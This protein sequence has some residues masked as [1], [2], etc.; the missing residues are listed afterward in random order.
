MGSALSSALSRSDHLTVKVEG[1]RGW[2]PWAIDVDRLEVADADGIWMVMDN[3]HCRWTMSA[4]MDGRVQIRSLGVQDVAIHRLPHAGESS[5]VKTN[6]SFSLVHPMNIMIDAVDVVRLQIDK[7]VA[8]FPLS[9]SVSSGGIKFLRDGAVLGDLMVRG[10]ATGSVFLNAQL[11]GSASDYLKLN[12]QLNEVLQPALGFSDFTGKAD[13][14]IRDGRVQANVS[15][16]LCKDDWKGQVKAAMLYSDQQLG[17]NLD[18]AVSDVSS[19]TY[20]FTSAAVLTTDNNS[21][22]ANIQTFDLEGWDSVGISLSGYVNPKEVDLFATLKQMDVSEIP[23]AVCSNFTGSVSGEFH[24]TG[25]PEHPEV[26]AT[27]TV[28]Q[29]S[30]MEDA[31]GLDLQMTAGIRDGSLFAS[32]SV[33]NSERGYLRGDLSLPCALSISPFVFNPQLKHVE[34]RVDGHMDLNGLNRLSRFD[35]QLIEGTLRTELHYRDRSPSGW[36]QVEDGRYEHYEWGMFFRDF[37][38]YLEATSD[39]FSIRS[40]EATDGAYGRLS[41]SGGLNRQGFGIRLNLADALIVRRDEVDAEVSGDLMISGSVMRPDIS[42]DLTINRAEIMLSNMAQAPPQVLTDF[43]R[44]SMRKETEVEIKTQSASRVG[45]DIRVAMP[46]QVFVNASMIEAVLGGELHITD[47]KKGTS[48]K[49]RIE[50]KRGFVSFIGKKFR[51]TEGYVVL[52]G[53]VPAQV[54]LDNLV[55]EYSR[56]DVIAR[57]ILSGPADDPRIRLESSPAMPEDE[58]LSHVLF[59]RDT[60]SITPYQAVQIATAARQLSA[61]L[62]GPG[63]MYQLRKAVGVDTLE[64]RESGV[65]GD[66]SSVAAGKYLMPGLYIELNRSLDSQ[67]QTGVTAEFELSRQFSVETYTGRKLRSGIGINWRKDY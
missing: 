43:D 30:S 33:T 60:G 41:M 25:S 51:F 2:I 48:I 59:D 11:T 66:A 12:A 67:G 44:D 35:G 29:F 9:Y 36:I 40:A 49:G 52:D 58:I 23:F 14:V 62:S 38:A 31:L 10:D 17:L 21:W 57:L 1:I 61:G 3:L 4:L 28:A 19:N 42:G 39:G 18:G 7:D 15:L 6:G 46:D 50:P 16:K 47:V 65:D 20:A 53:A 34:G 56:K 63:F 45:L 64:W 8:G 24:V 13:A 32:A 37:N 55:A 27:G 26:N 22:N 5:V 54:I